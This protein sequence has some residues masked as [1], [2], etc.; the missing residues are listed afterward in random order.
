MYVML[1][2]KLQPTNFALSLMKANTG[3]QPFPTVVMYLIYNTHKK[4]KKK[5]QTNTP[6]FLFKESHAL[7]ARTIPI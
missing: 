5:E 1:L 3:R 6:A 2:L 4:T 7:G